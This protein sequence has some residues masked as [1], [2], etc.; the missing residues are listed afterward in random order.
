MAKSLAEQILSLQSEEKSQIK[1]F[2]S[3]FVRRL[4]RLSDSQEDAQ[5][6]QSK[7]ED[8]IMWVDGQDISADFKAELFPK[9]REANGDSSVLVDVMLWAKT[10]LETLQSEAPTNEAGTFRETLRLITNSIRAGKTPSESQFKDLLSKTSLG[11]KVRYEAPAFVHEDGFS[12]DFHVGKGENGYLETVFCN[13][14]KDT[15]TWSVET[16]V[17]GNYQSSPEVD[18]FAGQLR[19]Y[20]EKGFKDVSPKESKEPCQEEAYPEDVR[21]QT[22]EVKQAVQRLTELMEAVGMDPT[23]FEIDEIIE[24]VN[25]VEAASYDY[26]IEG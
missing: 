26:P 17:G 22:W 12:M 15:N 8:L 10:E 1:S 14:D 13:Y 19:K 5:Q 2:Q 25:A 3:D 16:E 7:V 9:L 11:D 21:N 18:K 24:I 20:L 6:I 23:Q 4:K